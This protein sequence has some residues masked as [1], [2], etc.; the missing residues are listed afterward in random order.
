MGCCGSKKKKKDSEIKMDKQVVENSAKNSQ[1]PTK[2]DD[3]E[4]PREQ[5]Y[6]GKVDSGKGQTERMKQIEQEKEQTIQDGDFHTIEQV[7]AGN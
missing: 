6:G 4:N 1:A 3:E 5:A 7:G 2:K